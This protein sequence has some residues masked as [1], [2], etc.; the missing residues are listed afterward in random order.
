MYIIKLKFSAFQFSFNIGTNFPD[1]P[2][3]ARD[4]HIH[5]LSLGINLFFRITFINNILWYYILI[6]FYHKKLL[7]KNMM[8][9][10]LEM[11][12]VEKLKLMRYMYVQK[13]VFILES[14]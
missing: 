11:R 9:F 2:I 14:L 1:N 7:L 13:I 5:A 12:F 4:T 3:F 6:I 8:Y 10:S